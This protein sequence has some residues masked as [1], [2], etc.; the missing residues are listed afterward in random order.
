[1]TNFSPVSLY[2]ISSFVYTPPIQEQYWYGRNQGHYKTKL[3]W[4]HLVHSTKWKLHNANTSNHCRIIIVL[5]QL[6]PQLSWFKSIHWPPYVL[7]HRMLL[8]N[9]S[10]ILFE[11]LICGHSYLCKQFLLQDLDYISANKLEAWHRPR[12]CLIFTTQWIPIAQIIWKY[13]WDTIRNIV[14]SI[15]DTPK[16]QDQDVWQDQ[17]LWKRPR[18]LTR[19]RQTA[20]PS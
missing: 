4:S 17:D 14:P 18:P 6:E 13:Q 16:V 1:M 2:T 3:V 20:R 12:M 5:S 19:A 15:K 10:S 11:F 9:E 8:S 7:K